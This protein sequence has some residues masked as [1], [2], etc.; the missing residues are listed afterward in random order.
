MD[1]AA[2]RR[3]IEAGI[4]EAFDGV[5]LGSGV[6]LL[7]AQ[8]IDH[9]Y[10][11]G[12]SHAWVRRMAEIETTDDW[13]AIPDAQLRW[14]DATL[15]ERAI[16]DYWGD[17]LLLSWEPDQARSRTTGS[18]RTAPRTRTQARRRSS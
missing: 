3:A 5:A 13:M 7:H 10:E 17:I 16:R 4:R 15:V 1:R 8:A 18:R 6:S 2:E 14:E 12:Y 9:A 11:G